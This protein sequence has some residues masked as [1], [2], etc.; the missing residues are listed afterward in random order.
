[1]AFDL[2]QRATYYRLKAEQLRVMANNAEAGQKDL[3]RAAR[4]YEKLAEQC[5]KVARAIGHDIP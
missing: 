1:M 4:E 3:A 2:L 5:E